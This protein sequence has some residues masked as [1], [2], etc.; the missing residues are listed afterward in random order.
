MRTW[1]M[2]LERFE[3]LFMC[4]PVGRLHETKVL[5]RSRIAVKH[6]QDQWVFTL[7]VLIVCMTA[8]GFVW[9]QDVVLPNRETIRVM[10]FNIRYATK[11]DGENYWGNRKGLVV[12]RIKK[13]EVDVLGVQEA[14]QEQWSYLQRALRGYG[15]VG[16]GRDDGKRKGEACGIFYA[17]KRFKLLDKGHVWLSESPKKVG[18]KSWDSSLPRMF[19]WV[20]L[21]DLRNAKGKRIEKEGE[22]V[23]WVINTHWDHRGKK[24]R[25]ESAKLIT[26]WVDEHV[27]GQWG[28]KKVVVMGD[29]NC[30]EG[31][32]P[33]DVMNEKFVD[34]YRELNEKSA[35]EGTF[36]GFKNKKDGRR[37]DFVFYDQGLK[38][39]NAEIDQ[40]VVK[41]KRSGKDRLPSDHFPVVAVFEDS[42]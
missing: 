24:A 39:V 11:K 42:D 26:A 29:L 41:D 27:D 8:N 14:K 35:D 21:K 30:V 22:G 32:G 20:K 5:N 37:I 25:L 34:S 16:A 3:W 7:T 10:S 9:S 38:A 40:T 1:L 12:D 31:E 19:T 18:S 23:L 6:W 17:R 13:Q 33:I 28:E 15:Y 36:N 2:V 4:W